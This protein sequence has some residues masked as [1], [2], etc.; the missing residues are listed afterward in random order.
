M[1]A[2]EH[3]VQ[4]QPHNNYYYLQPGVGASSGEEPWHGE[5]DIV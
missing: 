4:Y 5:G 1:N 2:W 3:P